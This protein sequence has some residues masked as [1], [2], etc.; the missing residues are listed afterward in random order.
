MTIRLLAA[1]A[2]LICFAIPSTAK[3]LWK[4]DC[5]TVEAENEV[6]VEG[7]KTFVVYPFREPLTSD[8][9]L[10]D[11]AEETAEEIGKLTR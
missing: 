4:T 1:L 6:H 11:E 5:G 7:F 2:A 8:N 9:Q 3:A 10:V